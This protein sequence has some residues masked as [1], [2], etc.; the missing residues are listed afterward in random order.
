MGQGRAKT[1]VG[2]VQAHA[3]IQA[4]PPGGNLSFF[5]VLDPKRT[6]PL[7][8]TGP[9][10]LRVGASIHR[11]RE[12]NPVLMVLFELLDAALSLGF[13]LH[14]WGVPFFVP[15][16]LNKVFCHLLLAKPD[17][18]NV[19]SIP[20]C[21]LPSSSYRPCQNPALCSRWPASYS[22]EEKPACTESTTSL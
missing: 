9:W 6:S 13:S 18:P 16:S 1:Q 19:F 11:E 4:S 20:P 14:V 2:L 10:H 15:V 21:S 17:T 3:R 5:A 22:I 7:S 12:R 8:G